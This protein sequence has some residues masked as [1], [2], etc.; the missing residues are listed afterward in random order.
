MSTTT[1]IQNKTDHFMNKKG[2]SSF[3]VKFHPMDENNENVKSN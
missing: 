2:F 1:K 3:K